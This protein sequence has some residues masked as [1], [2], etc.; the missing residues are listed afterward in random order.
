M[1]AEHLNS[2][3]NRSKHVFSQTDRMVIERA[4]VSEAARAAVVECAEEA[5]L[6]GDQKAA[7]RLM[8]LV[9]EAD[10]I[11]NA[12]VTLQHPPPLPQPTPRTQ[13]WPPQTSAAR[14]GAPSRPHPHG[15]GGDGS[16]T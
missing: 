4:S 9:G 12:A 2:G 8:V 14:P 15:Q 5:R 1:P 7:D 3:T 11:L 16:M 10:R 13:D 6:D